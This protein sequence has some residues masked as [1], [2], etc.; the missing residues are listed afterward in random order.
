MTYI[1]VPIRGL[2]LSIALASAGLVACAPS[3]DPNRVTSAAPTAGTDVS[4]DKMDET[5]RQI[6]LPGDPRWSH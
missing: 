5:Y 6:Y 3:G 4:A 2:A 1:A